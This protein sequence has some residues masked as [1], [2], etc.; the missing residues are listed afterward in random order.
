MTWVLAGV[1][2]V[3]GCK[4]DADEGTLDGVESLKNCDIHAAHDQFAE[5]HA[6]DPEH[7]EAALGFGLTDLALLPEDPIV[8][9]ILGRVGFTAAIDMQ[10]LVFGEDGLLARAARMNSCD[11]LEQYARDTIPYPPLQDETIDEIGLIE[12]TLKGTDVQEALADLSPRFL[13]IAEALETAA[14]QM[15]EPVTIEGGCGLGTITVQAPELYLA[16][17]LLRGVVAGTALAAAYDWSI[18]VQDL[19]WALDVDSPMQLVNIIQPTIGSLSGA[20]GGGK[21][22]MRAALTLVKQG[23]E[24]AK[25]T[26]LDQDALFDWTALPGP[27]ADDL[28]RLVDSAIAAL[29]GPAPVADISPTLMV[30][31]GSL[32]DNPPDLQ[33]G[34]PLFFVD[35]TDPE[36]PYWDISQVAIEQSLGTLTMPNIFSDTTPEM[37]WAAEEAWNAYDESGITLPAERYRTVYDCMQPQ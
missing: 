33:G 30:D 3:A 4:S 19:A 14:D 18:G 28:I 7:P 24:A 22:T 25:V 35:N 2:A 17:G 26:D 15:A 10:V 27:R 6:D 16:A 36:F 9:E 11:S 29:D 32:F 12:P 13:A 23:L 5:A 37:S 21:D 31:L 8:T 20:P 1:A 34:E